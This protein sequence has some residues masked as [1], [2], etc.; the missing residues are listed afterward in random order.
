M[1]G[2]FLL[3]RSAGGGDLD[4]LPVTVVPLAHLFLSIEAGSARSLNGAPLQSARGWR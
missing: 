2:Q 4:Y 1:T 3:R